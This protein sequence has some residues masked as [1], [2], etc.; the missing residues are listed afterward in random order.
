MRYLVVNS[1]FRMIVRR[2]CA[3]FSLVAWAYLLQMSKSKPIYW[4]GRNIA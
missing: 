4:K 3:F 1:L 2:Y